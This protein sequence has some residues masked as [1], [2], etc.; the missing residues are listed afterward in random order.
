MGTAGGNG[1]AVVSQPR[2]VC[3]APG[4]G[5]EPLVAAEERARE[6]DAYG[7]ILHW[8]VMALY[9]LQLTDFEKDVRSSLVIKPLSNF[10]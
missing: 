10:L 6:Q 9:S 4:L 3:T 5:H 8:N 7:V 1:I 2:G